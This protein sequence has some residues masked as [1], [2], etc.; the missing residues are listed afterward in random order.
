MA[1]ENN[2]FLGRGW[3]FPPAFDARTG[4]L[5]MV[6]AEQDIRESLYILF[7][8]IP[9][10]RIMVPRYGCALHGLVFEGISE[11]L[12]TQIRGAIEDA[13]LFFE[14]RIKVASID[15]SR[16][17]DADGLLLIALEYTIIQTNTRSNMVYPFYLTE[18]TNVARAD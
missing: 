3:S 9:G 7:T 6:A 18:G 15:I 5:N 17:A 11:A 14:P 2:G 12:L 4:D 1:F 16:S 13:I 10:E 8:T